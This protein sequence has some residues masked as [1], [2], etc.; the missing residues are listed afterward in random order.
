[1]TLKAELPDE[2]FVIVEGVLAGQ[3]HRELAESLGI[4][5][6]T[7]RRRLSRVRERLAPNVANADDTAHAANRPPT[8]P[9]VNYNEFVL[10]KLIGSGGFGKVY[11]ASMQADGRTVAAVKFLRKVFWQN[12]AARGSFLSEINLA[13]K[14]THPCVIRYLGYGESPHGGPYVISEWIDGH[15]LQDVTD[16]APKKIIHWLQQICDAVQAVH[17]AG[18]VHGDL[19]PGNVLVDADNRITITDFGFSQATI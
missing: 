13:S 18:L 8:L 5:E 9:R 12:E 11:R 16:V 15:S 6:R 1:M 7:V 4:D 14:I 17:R 2:L 19:T 3:T 10:G